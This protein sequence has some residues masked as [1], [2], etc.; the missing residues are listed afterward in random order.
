MTRFR[1]AKGKLL[2]LAPGS[3]PEWK[4]VNLVYDTT[5]NMFGIQVL[6]GQL[7]GHCFFVA[8]DAL[9]ATRDKGT[10]T[11]KLRQV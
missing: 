3:E 5:N 7:Q 11:D 9:K 8:Q 10:E 1:A 6:D 4:E 2:V